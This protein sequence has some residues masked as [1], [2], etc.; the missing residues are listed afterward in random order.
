[1]TVYIPDPG[2]WWTPAR[3]SELDVAARI[4]TATGWVE[5]DDEENGYVLAAE[6]F[7]ERS[8]T[9]RKTEITSEFVGGSYVTRSVREQITETLSLY[10]YGINAM[11]LDDRIDVVTD[12]LEQLNYQ[13]VVRFG[14]S[15]ETYTCSPADYTVTTK[16]EFRHATMAQIKATV[17]RLPAT[18]RAQ[19][20]Y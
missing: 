2:G 1:M 19:V 15:Q 16:Q 4:H 8:V 9:H 7:G 3:A 12:A 5:L 20:H 11:Q 13:M 17:P 6:S 14:N 18:T 10:V